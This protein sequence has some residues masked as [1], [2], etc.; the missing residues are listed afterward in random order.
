MLL[1]ALV[2]VSVKVPPFVI[3][4]ELLLANPAPVALSKTGVSP[5]EVDGM[6]TVKGAMPLVS[7]AGSPVK[8]EIV[9]DAWLTTK[10]VVTC[11]AAKL[12]EFPDWSAARVTVPTPVREIELEV[13]TEAG[14]DL[15]E[16]TTG[17][18]EVDV[19]TMIV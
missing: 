2:A 9:C 3:V 12:L 4:T 17:S 5:E 16:S 7:F 14:P 1:P 11:G 19:G 6:V 8:E 18:F 15:T 10:E 13:R